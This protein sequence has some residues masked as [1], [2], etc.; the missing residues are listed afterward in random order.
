MEKISELMDGELGARES[1]AQIRMLEG[2]PK[3]AES[4]ETYH[5]I[6]DTLRNEIDVGPQFR[7]RLHELLK[8]EPAIVAPHTRLTARVV[9][10]TLPMAAGVAG[11][12]VV[13]WLALANAPSSPGG[14]VAPAAQ[15]LASVTEKPRES[16][17]RAASGTPVDGK[18]RDYLLAHQ[19]FS[20]STAMQGVASY[21][22]TVSTDDTPGQ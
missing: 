5:L 13:G 6:R 21:V 4:W 20:P 8:E 9:R 18:V 16:A 22:R 12:A 11:V 7:Q 14:P 15:T 10:Y 19:E 1:K 3:L 17:Q 2:D